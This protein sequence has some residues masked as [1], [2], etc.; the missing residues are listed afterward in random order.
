LPKNKLGAALFRN[1]YVCNDANHNQE[2]QK[3]VSINLND[4]N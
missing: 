2:S 1:L 3:P 4:V